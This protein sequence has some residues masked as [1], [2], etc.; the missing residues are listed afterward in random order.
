[1]RFEA[2]AHSEG[3][4]WGDRELVIVGRALHGDS[5]R[6]ASSHALPAAVG[7]RQAALACARPRPRRRA[8]PGDRDRRRRPGAR[9]RRSLVQPYPHASRRLLAALAEHSQAA[10][11]YGLTELAGGGRAASLSNHLGW[12]PHRLRFGPLVEHML[13]VRRAAFADIGGYPDR[14]ATRRMGGLRPVVRLRRPR[15]RRRAGAGNPRA[16]HNRSRPGA[17]S[18]SGRRPGAG[19]AHPARTARMPGRDDRPWLS[20]ARPCA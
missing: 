18:R 19:L 11:A 3:G 13:L 9:A 6:G 5:W 8:Q 16:S 4:D 2:V 12:D 17:P 1:M 7:R 10:F 15:V 14:P 20:G